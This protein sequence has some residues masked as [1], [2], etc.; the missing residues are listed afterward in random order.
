MMAATQA[1]VGPGFTRTLLASRKCACSTRFPPVNRLPQRGYIM[2]MSITNNTSQDYWFG[3]L[4]IGANASGFQV[5]D[6]TATSLYLTDD[7]VADAINN[8]SAAGKIT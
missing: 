4:H 7:A 8:L 2:A 6:T 5:D 3:P 1:S